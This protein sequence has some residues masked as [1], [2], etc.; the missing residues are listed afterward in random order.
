MPVEDTGPL[1]ER[2]Q[3]DD[4]LRVEREKA[5]HALEEE[6]AAIDEIADAVISRARARADAVLAAAR[7]KTD[8]QP[9][10]TGASAQSPTI[11]ETERRLADEVLREERA[12]ADETLLDE[13]EAH[14]ARL[15]TER[16]ETDKHLFT[17]RARSD[18]ALATRDEFL[19]VVSH[20]LRN[21]LN[22][23]VGFASVIAEE[24][25]QEHH[26]EAVRRH[27]QRIQRS[28]A[29]MSRLVGDLVDV[30]SI[31]AGRLAVRCES[32]DPTE[33]VTEAVETFQAHASASGVALASEIV[34]P[35]PLA[36]FDPARL[37]QV[38]ANL[39]SNAIK[40]T[41]AGGDVVVH[42]ERVGD[43]IQFAVSDTGPGI[44][45]DGLEA[46]FVRFLQLNKNDRRGVG[47]GLYI[48]KSIVQ[49]HGG[50]IWAESRIG[51]G[52]TFYFTLPIPVAP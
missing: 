8:R 44:P 48:A 37:L 31:E 14:A 33:V 1:S 2:A 25:S 52:S 39:L 35:L 32:G 21:M 17:E 43:H 5:D 38:F 7:T 10:L 36:A 22:A 15:S 27:A 19:G 45:P 46:V 47:L 50:R 16:E 30:A 26:V 49:G 29:R 24:V 34:P 51:E 41:P 11:I 4:S 20:D 9:A 42:V 18:D 12:D 3:T 13:R 6:L 23:V 28:G 40:F